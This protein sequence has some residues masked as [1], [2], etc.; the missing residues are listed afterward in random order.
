MFLCWFQTAGGVGLVES[1]R[2][3]LPRVEPPMRAGFTQVRLDYQVRLD[4]S[5][6][7]ALGWLPRFAD[8]VRLIDDVGGPVAGTKAKSNRQRARQKPPSTSVTTDVMSSA[9]RS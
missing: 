1:I 2:V 7:S 5:E 6:D 8:Y 4:L 9:M 3:E